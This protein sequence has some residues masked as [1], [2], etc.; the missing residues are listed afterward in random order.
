MKKKIHRLVLHRETLTS[1]D[2]KT[3]D[4]ADARGGYSGNCVTGRG[5]LDPCR[6]TDPICIINQC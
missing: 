3:T 1:L 2:M 6:R 4:V 5:S